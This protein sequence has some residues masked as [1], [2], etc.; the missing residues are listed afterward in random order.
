MENKII[1]YAKYA[2]LAGCISLA[3]INCN[4]ESSDNR[5]LSDNKAKHFQTWANKTEPSDIEKAAS[6]AALA[7]YEPVG[8]GGALAAMNGYVISSREEMH[9]KMKKTYY[10]TIDETVEASYDPL[11]ADAQKW[12][13]KYG[14]KLADE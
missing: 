4:K 1:K 5:Q 11:Y 14:L 6:R 10:E 3:C 2:F 13:Q 9:D 12:M 7:I 8:N